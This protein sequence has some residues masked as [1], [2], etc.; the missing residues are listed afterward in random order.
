MSQCDLV[1][2]DPA[3][4]QNGPNV[5]GRVEASNPVRSG[6]GTELNHHSPH[7]PLAKRLF[8]S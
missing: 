1:A 3:G 4:Q 5:L 6:A 7:T 2:V 8:V